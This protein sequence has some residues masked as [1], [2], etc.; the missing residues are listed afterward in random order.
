MPH[1]A[2][3]TRDVLSK[4]CTPEEVT[5]REDDSGIEARSVSPRIRTVE[6][7]LRH[8]EADMQV[9]EVASSEA[10]KWEGL[11]ADRETGE[12]VVTEL[13]RVH[14]R[15]RPK[16]G[17]TTR[18]VVAAMIDAASGSIRQPKRTTPRRAKREGLLQ[19]VVVADTHF[20]KYAWHRT[21]GGDDYDLG[22]ADS[23]VRAAGNELMDVGDC[24]K[25]TRRV[26]AMVGD[27][28]HYD[29]PHGTTT[30]GTALERDG[31]LQKMIHVGS[32]ALLSIIERSAET[33]PTDVVIVNGNHDETLTWA[34]QRIAAERFRDSRATTVSGEFSGRQYVRHGGNLLGFAH[35]HK[36]KRKLPQIMAIERATEWA[37]CRYREW[38]TGHYHSQA[39]EWQRPIETLDSVIVRTAPALCPP[40]DWHSTHGFIGSRQC[41]ETFLYAHGG[42]LVAMAVS[43]PRIKT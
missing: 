33:C 18:E 39:A 41:M 11:T 17:P 34:F 40:D 8:I 6:D 19:V 36:A 15:L 24:H 43:E 20:G 3:L 25:P 23:V 32:N 2:T 21:T 27:L 16:G 1:K 30:A 42:G 22:I 12:P 10:T 7:L 4:N 26:I 37:E 5:K 29:S 13:H 14:V 28:F 31:R 9:W 38:H 35:G